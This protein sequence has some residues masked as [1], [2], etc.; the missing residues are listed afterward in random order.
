VKNAVGAYRNLPAA[1][2]GG[3]YVVE[4][5]TGGF[6]SYWGYLGQEPGWGYARPSVLTA[7]DTDDTALG[8]W[9]AL[10]TRRDFKP[11]TAINEPELALAA[12]PMNVL[13]LP[14]GL[15]ADTQSV[16]V[17][18]DGSASEQ[19]ALAGQGLLL[20]RAWSGPDWRVLAKASLSMKPDNERIL[21][22]TCAALSGDDKR[23]FTLG[24]TWEDSA[25]PLTS[26]ELDF[27]DAE[28]TGTLTIVPSA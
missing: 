9:N 2:P 26:L 5:M 27:G 12:V 19:A 4:F 25:T 10:L 7:A 28:F 20:A 1:G 11:W 15:A 8:N 16:V 22:G 23:A 24:G 21:T 13:L 6:P 18:S 3:Y 17:G 14:N